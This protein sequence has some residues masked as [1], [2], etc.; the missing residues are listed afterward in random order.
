MEGRTLELGGQDPAP[1]RVSFPCY[2]TGPLPS[3]LPL[4][5]APSFL[6]PSTVL[7]HPWPLSTLL[8]YWQSAGMQDRSPSRVK[9]RLR[10][11]ALSVALAIAMKTLQPTP[12]LL[13]LQKGGHAPLFTPVQGLWGGI[14]GAV[15]PSK[16][17]LSP[18]SPPSPTGRTRYSTVHEASCLLMMHRPAH[19]HARPRW[20][21]NEPTKISLFP[22]C[23][24]ATWSLSPAFCPSPE[25]CRA[26]SKVTQFPP[27]CVPLSCGGGGV[28]MCAGGPRRRPQ[29]KPTKWTETQKKTP[30]F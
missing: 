22:S 5:C 15:S 23:S 18:C 7:H 25:L 12:S 10:P 21:G 2:T 30:H 9:R 19:E 8:G 26:V 14:G 27:E 24:S 1:P 3:P 13:P 29:W 16:P 6:P 20:H 11:S 4:C 17:P 28:G